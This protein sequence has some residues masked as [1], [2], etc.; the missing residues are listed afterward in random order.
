MFFLDFS[1]GLAVYAH[2]GSR[3]GLKTTDTDFDAAGFA[4]AV[5]FVFDQLQGL[6]DFLDQLALA[7]AGAQFQ[8]E[9]FF[10][11]GRVNGSIGQLG[12]SSEQVGQH[13]EELSSHCKELCEH[14][15]NS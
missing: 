10:S 9:F 4:P 5:F 13:Q 8:A 2:V 3:T 14:G 7:I 15:W 12:T 11:R 6:V 1:Q